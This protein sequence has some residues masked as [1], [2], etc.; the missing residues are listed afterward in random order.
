MRPIL[1][2]I[3][4]FQLHTYGLTAAAGFLLALYYMQWQ[5]RR[6]RL[7]P[8]F[9]A[10]LA[11]LFVIVGV[12]GARALYVL[13]TWERFED[14]FWDVF[15]IWKGG[16]VFYGGPMLVV[17]VAFWVFRR[18]NVGAFAYSD[19][20]AVAMMLSLG[21]GRFGCLAAGCCYGKVTGV[22]WGVVYPPAAASDYLRQGLPVH[23]TPIYEFLACMAIVGLGI[24]LN[25][26]KK[27][28]GIT[29]GMVFIT[30][31]IARSV[32]ELYRGDTVR[33]FVGDTGLSTS[34]F[35]SLFSVL[36]GL[37][38]IAWAYWKKKPRYYWDGVPPAGQP[39][40]KGS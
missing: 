36:F 20:G 19:I 29:T 27:H 25:Q 2:E 16:L 8:E 33:G 17:P 35:I 21:I 6:I 5:A 4:P 15:A 24:V 1:F 37:G 40:P 38:I 7:D 23:P 14:N 26:Y 11:F 12:I 32:I 13:V 10:D 3:G 30:Y 31:A 28:D 9:A 18:K 22:P 39:A 34:Q